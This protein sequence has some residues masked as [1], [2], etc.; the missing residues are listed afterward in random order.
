MSNKITRFVFVLIRIL[1]Y[2][3]CFREVKYINIEK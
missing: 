2:K 1:R 3:Y